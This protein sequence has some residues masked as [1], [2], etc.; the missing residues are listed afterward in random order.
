MLWWEARLLALALALAATPALAQTATQAPAKPPAKAKPPEGKTVETLT[1]TGASPPDAESSIDRR[2]YT[3]GKDLQ[4]TTG[5]IADALRNLPSVDVDVQGNLSLRGDPNVT[6]LVDGKPSPM[7]DGK[8]RADALQQLPADQIERVEVI[9]NPSA[10]LNPEGSGGVI[11]L[12]TKKSRGKGVTGSAYVTA[13]S[14]GL[15]RAGA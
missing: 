6:I 15:K 1:V 5:S 11:N 10:A 3:L 7:F 9:T 2:S 4:A 12:I 14:A 13:G 8:G